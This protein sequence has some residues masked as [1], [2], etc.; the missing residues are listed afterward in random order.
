MHGVVD[1]RSGRRVRDSPHA[2]GCRSPVTELRF[3]S[4]CIVVTCPATFTVSYVDCPGAGTVSF[5]AGTAW[6]TG[7]LPLTADLRACPNGF[8]TVS[9]QL[10]AGARFLL[11]SV[12]Y[13]CGGAPCPQWD[14]LTATMILNTGALKIVTGASLASVG[15]GMVVSTGDVSIGGDVL[16]LSGITTATMVPLVPSSTT[17]SS[18]FVGIAGC[19]PDSAQIVVGATLFVNCT[20]A[21]G[22]SP[23]AVAGIAVGAVL[24]GVVVGVGA[25]LGMR[26]LATVRS[27]QGNADLRNNDMQHA[28][29]IMKE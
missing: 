27:A 20:P 13:V 21:S 29:R 12:G 26:H 19:T 3:A 5:V 25:V 4:K 17:L 15:T 28:Y 16:Q 23:G 10:Q 9:F 24:V 11:D 22:L 18:F 8:A 2:N 1:G 14:A 7:A 6:A